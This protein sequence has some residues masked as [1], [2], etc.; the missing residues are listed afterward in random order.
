MPSGGGAAGSEEATARALASG[1]RTF[2]RGM[3]LA[4]AAA[5]GTSFS[6]SCFFFFFEEEKKR[7]REKERDEK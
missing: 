2:L 6:S 3:F 4:A 7:A 1:V 5:P